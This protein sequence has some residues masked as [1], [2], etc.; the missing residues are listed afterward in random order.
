MRKPHLTI[1][2]IAIPLLAAGGIG[3]ALA[4]EN[5][6]SFCAA[7]HTEPEYKYYQQSIQPN[8][9][10][11]AAHHTQKKIA[12]I[13]CHSGSGTFGRDGTSITRCF[14][15]TSGRAIGWAA[16]RRAR[17]DAVPVRQLSSSGDHDEPAGR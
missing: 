14:A 7:C 16:A 15:A 1:I 12:C 17:F 5:Q 10:T 8:A 4:L 2:V 11:L 13:D 6:D 9:A 3:A